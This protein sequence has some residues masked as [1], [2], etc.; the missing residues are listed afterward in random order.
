MCSASKDEIAA[1]DERR[2]RIETLRDE[3]VE[4]FQAAKAAKAIK[5]THEILELSRQ[6]EIFP[7]YSEQYENLARIYSAIKDRKNMLKYA[8]MALDTLAEQGYIDMEPEFLPR[9][10]KS[11][12]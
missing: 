3:V 5:L 2:L 6:E 8:Q 4:A 11:L 7:L 10:V 9:L 1:S 12:E